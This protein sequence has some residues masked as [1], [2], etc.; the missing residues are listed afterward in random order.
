MGAIFKIP[1]FIVYFVAGI[2]GLFICLS[3]VVDQLGFLGGAVAFA[4]APFTLMFAPW[5]A[6]LA[7]QNW[8]PL[9]L[10]YGSGIAASVLYGIGAAI[11][12][13]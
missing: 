1:A 4:I 8:F 3:I 6:A 2:W 12:G 11:D 9:A 7:E 13:D 10:V 5:Y